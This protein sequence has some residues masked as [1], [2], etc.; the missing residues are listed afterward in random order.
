MVIYRFTPARCL[1]DTCFYTITGIYARNILIA[2]G[3]E[4]RLE[5]L[6]RKSRKKTGLNII[7]VGCGKVGATLTE[8]LSKESHDI[9]LIDKN[10][11][12]IQHL[13][14]TY[15]VMGLAGNGASYNVQM[16]AG[17]EDAD[18]LIAVTDSDEL[19]LLCCTVAK[20]VGDCAAIARVRTPDYSEESA[21]LRQ[22]LGLALIINPELAAAHEV[23]RLLYLP[24]ALEV[25]PFAHGR[26]E[27]IK[28][29]LPENNILANQ[30]IVNLGKKG[31]SQNVLFC[32]VE[33]DGEIIIP[34][35]MFT[36]AAGDVVS[37]VS[38]RRDARNFLSKIGF[39]IKQ[40]NNTMII[41]GG[42]AA[43]YLAKQLL[44]MGI[45]VKII[46]SNFERCEELNALLPKAIIINGDG[47]N[48]ELLKEE[49]IKNIESF[50]P[51]TGIDEENIFLT[52]YAREVSNAK[53]ITKINRINFKNVISH[54][55]LGSVIYPKYITAEAILAYVRAKTASIGSNVETLYHMFDSR[56]EALEFLID[57]ESEVTNIP[58][59]EM[60]LKK[61]LLLCCIQRNGKTIIPSGTDMIMPGDTVVIVTTHTGF[62]NIQ[63]ILV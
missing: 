18:L 26:V 27:L 39:D 38:S 30:T 23:A 45:D 15:D 36:L 14:N 25:N 52:L 37:F 12:K 43:Y 50:V 24:T 48:E 10:P 22:K 9:T 61:N 40:V 2:C 41:G 21:Y 44:P 60:N 3:A 7:I 8:Q 6:G 56:V 11:E 33:R 62:D 34:T 54:L 31:V 51:L 47:T 19:N 46:E 17:I 49:G 28:F 4:M 13:A 55:D 20:R 1:V 35:G 16:E 32:A 5:M 59:M 63:D 58:I 53:V 57:R 42:K 29:K